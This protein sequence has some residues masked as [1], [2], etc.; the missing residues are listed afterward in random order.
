VALVVLAIDA[1]LPEA[2]Q[3]A[4]AVWI[5]QGGVAVTVL[6]EK[7]ADG[8]RKLLPPDLADPKR[9]AVTD[10]AAK[11]EYALLS[12]IDLRHPLF[13]PFDDPRY[14]DFTK[15]RFWRHREL[16]LDTEA[17]AK[18]R[19]L[20]RFD[21]G[22]P[23]VVEAPR[24]KGRLILLASGWQPRESQLGV[25]SKF[26]PLV[27]TL[28][29]L[30]RQR[31]IPVAQYEFGDEIELSAPAE[32]TK[33][34]PAGAGAAWT[35]RTPSGR[36]VK[37]A[38]DAGRYL[39][40]ESPG[41]YE[42][43]SGDYLHR[44]A[45]NVPADESRTAPLGPEALEAVGVRLLKE[46]PAATPELEAER[47]TLQQAEIEARQQLWRPLLAFA[48]GLTIVETWFAGRSAGREQVA[49]AAPDESK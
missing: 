23:A 25:S 3:T 37:L 4:L 35:V 9:I 10:P 5:E 14:S 48:I 27:F 46:T 7:G 8:W 44:A 36:E 31:P 18:L 22:T 41:V 17:A 38:A 30:G 29:D 47:R 40:D 11:V 1:P 12:E 43:R 42:L 49:A 2:W 6:Q 28:V 13:A 19:V 39:P 26:V 21:G 33:S 32:L 45:V 34:K 15:I 20:A 16:K 24:G